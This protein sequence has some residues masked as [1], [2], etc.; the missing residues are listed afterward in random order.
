LTEYPASK[1]IGKNSHE[2]QKKLLCFRSSG[3]SSWLALLRG[4]QSSLL[5]GVSLR[6]LRQVALIQES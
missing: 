1:L 5:V 3:A 2:L 6:E 4:A